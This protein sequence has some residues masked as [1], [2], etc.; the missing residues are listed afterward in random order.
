MIHIYIHVSNHH[1]YIYRDQK[2]TSVTKVESQNPLECVWSS[3]INV[4]L[5]KNTHMQYNVHS[6]T[7]CGMQ[8]EN[9]GVEE[10][11]HT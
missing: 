9:H 8:V 10:A 2:H 3:D 6:M 7:L 1:G 4:V 5:V 11:K